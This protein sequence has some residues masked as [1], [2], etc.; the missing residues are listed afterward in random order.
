M[1]TYFCLDKKFL[2][3]LF[4][5]AGATY[6]DIEKIV[7]ENESITFQW[8]NHITEC[9]TPFKKDYIIETYFNYLMATD[10]SFYN[11][12]K[13]YGVVYAEFKKTFDIELKKINDNGDVLDSEKL[14]EKVLDLSTDGRMP[15]GA[16]QV[17]AA[18]DKK[19]ETDKRN[20]KKTEEADAAA[21]KL[22]KAEDIDAAGMVVT[23]VETPGEAGQT[24]GD[25]TKT[26][27]G[28][29]GTVDA[30][31]IKEE[32]KEDNTKDGQ[33]TADSGTAETVTVP[34]G[35]KRTREETAAGLSVVDAYLLR[36][37]QND[38][39]DKKLSYLE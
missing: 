38:G 25:D 14:F 28:D 34:R 30:A 20:K 19:N 32:T 18:K 11:K 29:T 33:A 17:A 24:V 15:V 23:G 22:P 2:D 37:G 12:I 26:T 10:A 27:S 39:Q 5:E 8:K 35:F 3:V 6:T 16:G 21:K 4:H 36:Q 9:K 31:D 7:F 13:T 1:L